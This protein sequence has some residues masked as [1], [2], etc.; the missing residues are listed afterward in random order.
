MIYLEPRS[1]YDTAIRKIDEKKDVVI[2]DFDKLVEII[3]E[4]MKEDF[5]QL[6]PTDLYHHAVEHIDFNIEAMHV[7]YPDWPIISYPDDDI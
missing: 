1:F 4:N 6:T 2:Y 3:A 7:N 5:P